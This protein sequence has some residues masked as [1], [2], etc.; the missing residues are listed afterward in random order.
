ME[1]HNSI[2]KKIFD[3][4]NKSFSFLLNFDLSIK[5]WD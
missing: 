1:A 5:Q 3:K 2:K 4:T